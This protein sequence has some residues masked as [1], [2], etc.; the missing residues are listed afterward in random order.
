MTDLATKIE[1]SRRNGPEDKFVNRRSLPHAVLREVRVLVYGARLALH[2]ARSTDRPAYYRLEARTLLT[3]ARTLVTSTANQASED[4]KTAIFA[5]EPSADRPRMERAQQMHTRR[6]ANC[7]AFSPGVKS[8]RAKPGKKW[9]QTAQKCRKNCDLLA[10]TRHTKQRLTGFGY[11]GRVV[12]AGPHLRCAPHKGAVF[13]LRT[14]G[15]I[16]PCGATA[17]SQVQRH[18]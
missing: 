9:Q 2:L 13:A 14:Q 18:G 8:E 5:T 11:T 10:L 4:P 17:N 3:K 15:P 16:L 1:T 6:A 12:C 7:L